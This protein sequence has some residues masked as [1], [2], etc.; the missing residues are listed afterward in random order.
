VNGVAGTILDGLSFAYGDTLL[1][2]PYRE[3]YPDHVN[4]FGGSAVIA[5]Y[6]NGLNAAT[7]FAGT[8]PS[9]TAPGSVAFLGIPF[10]TIHAKAN[11]DALMTRVLNH[12][13]IV[14]AA[15]RTEPGVLPHGFTLAQN[16]PNPFNPSTTVRFSLPSEEHVTLT[17]FDIMGREVGRLAEGRY[18]AGEYSVAWDASRF[19]SGVYLCRL[20]AGAI[21]LSRTMTLM[22]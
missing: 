14:T 5:K 3:D 12:F 8:F 22:K 11:R 16:Y 7:M 18:A 20:T 2:S 1:G 6:A 9:G 19:A 15:P 17:V 4:A 13:G 10:E 21:S